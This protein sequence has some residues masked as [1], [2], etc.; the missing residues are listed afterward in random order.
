MFRNTSLVAEPPQISVP[1][2]EERYIE[3]DLYKAILRLPLNN[4][5]TF[6]ELLSPVMEDDTANLEMNDDEII[7]MKQEV[8]EEENDDQKNEDVEKQIAANLEKL[9]SLAI[10]ASLLNVTNPRDRVVLRRI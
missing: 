7:A 8:E 5:M 2:M 9:K 6:E 4:P 10:T 3:I 1:N